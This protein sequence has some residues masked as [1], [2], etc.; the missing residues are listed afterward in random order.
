[1]KFFPFLL[2]VCFF[3]FSPPTAAMDKNESDFV[4]LPIQHVLL[5]KI[6]EDLALHVKLLQTALTQSGVLQQQVE[7]ELDDFSLD[8]D[9]LKRENQQLRRTCARY[10]SQIRSLEH[11][12]SHTTYTTQRQAEQIHNLR[13][14]NNDL[15]HDLRKANESA[16]KYKKCYKKAEKD[17][18]AFV[19]RFLQLSKK[20]QNT[21]KDEEQSLLKDRDKEDDEE[22]ER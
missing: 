8:K 6:N 21:E 22:E 16:T 18:L 1:M 4:P 12:L 9:T 17:L 19:S 15:Y 13:G 20:T 7:S 10:E 14:A 5:K 3:V 11:Q 2:V